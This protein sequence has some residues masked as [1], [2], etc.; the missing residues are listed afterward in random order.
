MYISAKVGNKNLVA[1]VDTGA[2]GF[3]FVSTNL[4]DRLHLKSQALE[5]PIAILGFEGK[6]S[7]RVTNSVS[8]PLIL[9]NHSEVV[10]AFVIPNSKHDL[11]LGLP[12]LEKHCPYID[13]KEHTITFGEPCLNSAC[14][15]FETTISYYNRADQALVSMKEPI[16]QLP[17]LQPTLTTVSQ[18][19]QLSAAAF[20]MATQQPG[21][22]T[23]TLSL[24]DLDVLLEDLPSRL[25]SMHVGNTTMIVPKDANPGDFL[26]PQY[27]EFLDVFDRQRANSLPPHRSWDH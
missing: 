7:S 23:F 2:S 26:P 12:W 27:H 8:F 21:C 10:S 16:A 11:I 18:P 1:L 13:W 3:A 5:S 25:P 19:A 9:G 17:P 4:C 14:C 15:H 6:S 24:R 22:Q 20:I